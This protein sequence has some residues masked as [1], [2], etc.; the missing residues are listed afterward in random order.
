MNNVLLNT[1]GNTRWHP[2]QKNLG[3]LEDTGIFFFRMSLLFFN[4]RK[5][6]RMTRR[7]L[8]SRHVDITVCTLYNVQA[9]STITVK[10]K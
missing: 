3:F 8:R 2:G 1:N 4:R 10:C 6:Y 9:S 5:A 7:C